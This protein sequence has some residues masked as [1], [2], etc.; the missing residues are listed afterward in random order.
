MRPGDDHR[1]PPDVP[2]GVFHRKN[3]KA[4]PYPPTWKLAALL[5]MLLLAAACGPRGEGSTGDPADPVRT[6]TLEASSVQET[7]VE[8]GAE[9]ESGEDA[10]VASGDRNGGEAGAADRIEGVR[11]QIFEDYERLIVDF[12][13]DGGDA[14]VPLWSVERP[15]DGG[16]VRL[17]FPGIVS[18][19]TGHEDLI[20]SILSEFY[21]VRDR[22]G[23]LFADVFAMHEFRYRV[24][25]RPE[26][27][28]LAVDFHGVPQ[29]IDFP[30]TTGDRAVVL[31][32]REAEEVESPLDVRGYAQPLRGQVTVSL[33]DREQ[34]VLA[35]KTVRVDDRAS[36]WSRFQTT[37]E[38]SGYEGLATIHI[39]SGSP[40]NGSLVGTETEVFLE[41]SGPG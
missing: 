2:V 10:F 38:F 22:D 1:R 35:T 31:Q 15:G 24:V 14:G 7:V 16:Y 3:T 29:E 19:A 4:C 13:G 34:D 5:F 39:V 33:F 11:F 40:N 23:G 9:P 25:E 17:R 36:A 27:G 18:T 8:D 32:P 30:P 41:S 6:E 21:V 28:Q 20:G 26:S 12:G 37:L